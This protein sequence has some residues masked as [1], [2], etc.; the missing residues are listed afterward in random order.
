[1]KYLL[2]LLSLCLSLSVFAQA[3]RIPV[4][5]NTWQYGEKPTRKDYLRQHMIQAWDQ[6]DQYFQTFIR[7]KK[8][9]KIQLALEVQE[10]HQGGKFEVSLGKQKRQIT[11]KAGATTRIKVGAF[12][13]ADTGYQAIVIKAKS[14]LSPAPTIVAY[15]LSGDIKAADLNFVP[16]NE[17]NFYYWG[18]RG[19]SVHLNY[20]VPANESIE[21]YYNEVTVP[22]GNDVQGSY[23]MANGFAEGYFGMQV[24]GPQ[25]RRILF[26][27]WS[28][29]S[30]D[31]P[32]DI[33]ADQKIILKAKGEQVQTGEFGNEGSGGQSFLRYNWKAGNTYKFLLRGRPIANNYTEYTAWFFAP[34]LNKWQLIAS[35]Q[36]PKISTYLKSFHSFLENFD[37]KQGIHDRRVLFGNQWVYTAAGK[38]IPVQEARFTADNTAGKG[39]RMDYAGGVQGAQFYLRNFGFFADYTPIHTIFKHSASM[40]APS[41]DFASLLN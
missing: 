10:N 27:V 15:E 19:P 4:G 35:F 41:I 16:N 12:S 23:Y 40:Q 6:P 1:M 8:T 22:E 29:F 21:Y 38:W 31:N 25:E 14:L 33:P 37:P 13:I 9:G 11:L 5:G 7:F 28:P 20:K 17:G 36:R 26:S 39:Y 32:K 30:T 34:E 2:S 18:R 3:V 24:N